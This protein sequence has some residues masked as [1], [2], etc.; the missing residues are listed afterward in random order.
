MESQ[1]RPCLTSRKLPRKSDSEALTGAEK[2]S[3]W[4]LQVKVRS[5]R[6]T[7]GRPP[8]RVVDV[9]RL[10][11]AVQVACQDDWLPLSKLGEVRRKGGVPASQAVLQSFEAL[12]SVRHVCIHDCTPSSRTSWRQAALDKGNALD[13]LHSCLMSGCQ[14]LAGG[15]SS[16]AVHVCSVW[17]ASGT[18]E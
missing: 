13:L 15:S 9:N 3:V 8:L 12:T 17:Q 7:Q 11:R 1:P 2:H 10:R 18:G 16:A 4:V 6:S 14:A 5:W